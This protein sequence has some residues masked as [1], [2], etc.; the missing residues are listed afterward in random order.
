MMDETR[1]EYD[2][3]CQ[4][5]SKVYTFTKTIPLNFKALFRSFSRHHKHSENST[6]SWI[7][8]S[9]ETWQM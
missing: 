3:G 9:S 7:S 8:R 1:Y 6:W 5:N 2:I 4:R